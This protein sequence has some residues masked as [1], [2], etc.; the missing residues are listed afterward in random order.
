M[1]EGEVKNSQYLEILRNESDVEIRQFPSEVLAI[2]KAETEVII[3]ELITKNAMAARIYE[4]FIDFKRINKAWSEI[5][6]KVFYT[7]IA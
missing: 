5:T 6:E 2:L 7:E 4:S 3:E 1:A